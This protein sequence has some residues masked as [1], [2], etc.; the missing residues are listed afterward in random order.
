MPICWQV[1]L[2]KITRRNHDGHFFKVIDG[3][4]EKVNFFIFYHIDSEEVKTV[5]RVKEYNGE[6]F[7]SWVLLEPL[8]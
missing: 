5:L 8:E 7:G 4:R 1:R 2:G 6:E 3:Q